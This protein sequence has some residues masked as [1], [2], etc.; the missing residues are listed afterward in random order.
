MKSVIPTGPWR[1]RE[2]LSSRRQSPGCRLGQRANGA[3]AVPRTDHR[4]P[5]AA[6]ARN[7]TRAQSPAH[8]RSGHLPEESDLLKLFD[9]LPPGTRRRLEQK[10]PGV[11]G[12]HP[13]PTVYIPRHSRGPRSKLNTVRGM[14]IPARTFPGADRN[15]SDEGRD[16]G[17]H[18]HIRRAH[19]VPRTHPTRRPRRLT[20]D[21]M[22]YN[23]LMQEQ[24]QRV[25]H[26]HLLRPS[27]GAS[28]FRQHPLLVSFRISPR[29]FHHAVRTQATSPL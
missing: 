18:R 28:P 2:G 3:P 6:G 4:H 14:A 19:T 24:P 9:Q 21:S 29:G 12:V 20:Q 15:L 10:M 23:A 8:A 1:N 11:P 25:R 26:V 27:Y 5:H 16:V 22:P 13:Q 17:D 7:R